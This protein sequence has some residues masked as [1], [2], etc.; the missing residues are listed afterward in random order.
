MR[1]PGTP[2]EEVLALTTKLSAL[3]RY[4]ARIAS[5]SCLFVPG[6]GLELEENEEFIAATTD[7]EHLLEIAEIE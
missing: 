2:R 5:D 6:L 4:R 1:A 7:K 3:D